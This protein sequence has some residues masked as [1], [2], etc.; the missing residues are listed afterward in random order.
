MRDPARGPDLVELGERAVDQRADGRRVADGRDAAD[1]LA[2]RGP[3]EVGA[4]RRTRSAPMIAATFPVSTRCAPDVIT[5]SGAPSASN[6]SELAICP[7]SMPSAAAAAG[8]S[9]HGVG[10]YLQALDAPGIAP[11]GGQ[12]GDDEFDVAVHGRTLPRQPAR[13]RGD[14]ARPHPDPPDFAPL[15]ITSHPAGGVRSH[16]RGGEVR[17]GPAARPCR[18]AGL[19]IRDPVICVP[20]AA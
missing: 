19:A 13:S 6:T 18:Q 11:A 2:G 4:A 20:S 10:Q 9:R 3:H 5:S 7:T 1:G 16:Q 14:Y 8:R 15:R 17:H 12:I